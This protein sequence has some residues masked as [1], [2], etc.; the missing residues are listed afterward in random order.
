MQ[1]EEKERASIRIWL[2][3]IR[4]PNLLT[5]PG[6]PIAGYVLAGGA[7][8]WGGIDLL[9]AACIACSLYTAGIVM[10][11][12]LDVEEDRRRRPHRPYAA[13][14]IP[15]RDMHR[16]LFFLGGG[17]ILAAAWINALSLALAIIL[18]TLILAYN[19]W[20]RL[21]PVVGALFLGLCRACSFLLGAAVTGGAVT[22]WPV[23]VLASAG[24]LGAYVASFSVVAHWELQQGKA[25]SLSLLPLLL[26]LLAGP[27]LFGFSSVNGLTICLWLLTLLLIAEG[28]MVA[29]SGAA[30]LAI[31]R[32]IHALPVVQATLIGGAGASLFA[33]VI[34]ALHLPARWFGKHISAS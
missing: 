33:L 4:A 10:N 13:G 24:L 16:I 32:W 18:V 7:G 29:L 31:G 21:V 6:D 17:G 14:Y 12:L 20:A 30:P 25:R 34:A 26:W 19:G 11:D 2:Q 27:L 8:T 15:K 5:V 28:W 22:E 3:E 9:L 23:M 1:A